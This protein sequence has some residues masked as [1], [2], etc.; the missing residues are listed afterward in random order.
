MPI[1]ESGLWRKKNAPMS[2]NYRKG[3]KSYMG[4]GMTSQ[5]YAAGGPTQPSKVNKARG[6]KIPP[7]IVD[8]KPMRI[9]RKTPQESKVR[10]KPG[11]ARGGRFAKIKS[12]YD[13]LT[14][15]QKASDTMSQYFNR[16]VSESRKGRK[17][18]PGR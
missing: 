3:G 11:M 18:G 1:K 7:T 10:K 4:G 14:P 17:R 2:K 16:K 12:M 6:F 15:A 9:T 8:G 13:K 5:E